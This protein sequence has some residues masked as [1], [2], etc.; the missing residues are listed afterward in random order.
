M[1]VI[2]LFQLQFPASKQ[3]G[4]ERETATGRCRPAAQDEITIRLAERAG[5][6]HAAL[7]SLKAA[8]VRLRRDPGPFLGQFPAFLDEPMDYN[9]TL[10]FEIFI[11]ARFVVF[12]EVNAERCVLFCSFSRH[13]HIITKNLKTIVYN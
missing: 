3:M 10:A 8:R 4:K 11:P 9:E 1:L 2:N 13:G 6:T 7:Q 12:A 5:C